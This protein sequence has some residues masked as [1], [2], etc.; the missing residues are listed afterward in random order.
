M[1]PCSHDYIPGRAMRV[2]TLLALS[3]LA[4]DSNPCRSY[5]RVTCTRLEMCMG[6]P[7]S[8]TCTDQCL[9]VIKARVAA[10]PR[11]DIDPNP[12]CEALE[13]AVIDSDCRALLRAYGF[14][15]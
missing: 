7:P 3:L 8:P 4:C 11:K 5:C 13:S 2:L 1:L 14:S 10:M 12:T 6:A 15:N 9:A